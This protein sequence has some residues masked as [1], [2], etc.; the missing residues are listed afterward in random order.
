MRTQK[1]LKAHI[2]A[3]GCKV[4]GLKFYGGHTELTVGMPA[5]KSIN[6]DSYACTVTEIVYTK[7]GALKFVIAGR[8]KFKPVTSYSCGNPQ[9][10]HNSHYTELQAGYLWLTLGV[11]KDYL[12]PHF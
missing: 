3:E 4:T 8:E 7:A 6:G 9:D 5:T 2:E 12:D 10:G 11:A 1:A